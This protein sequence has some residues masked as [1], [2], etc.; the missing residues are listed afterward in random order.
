MTELVLTRVRNTLAAPFG[1]AKPHKAPLH[2][3]PDMCHDHAPASSTYGI[4]L[5]NPSEGVAVMWPRKEP[6]VGDCGYLTPS[7][8]FLSLFNVFET[9][10]EFPS[11]PRP[12]EDDFTTTDVPSG[13]N[14]TM[15]WRAQRRIS[16]PLKTPK[17]TIFSDSVE[18]AALVTGDDFRRIYACS[19]ALQDKFQQYLA[20][21]YA[22][23]AERFDGHGIKGKSLIIVSQTTQ[24][25]RFFCVSQ[26]SFPS[27]EHDEDDPKIWEVMRK[28]GFVSNGGRTGRTIEELRME[29]EGPDHT[30]MFTPICVRT[31]SVCAARR[32]EPTTWELTTE[33]TGDLVK[34]AAYACVGKQYHPTYDLY[35]L[36]DRHHPPNA[37]EELLDIALAENRKV[38]IAVGSWS[39]VQSLHEQCGSFPDLMNVRLKVDVERQ[40]KMIIGHVRSAS[41]VAAETTQEKK[42]G[43][44][45]KMDIDSAGFDNFVTSYIN[46]LQVKRQPTTDSSLIEIAD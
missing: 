32:P 10:H 6:R 3:R 38:D 42:E 12:T 19:R 21:N 28:T 26:K 13:P 25:V 24:L 35:D 36:D 27:V 4:V 22:A 20:D 44:N 1:G 14:H 18:D 29:P 7:T 41:V 5:Q 2:R 15:T 16:V 11:I 9:T 43:S 30:V 46:Q 17:G 33:V 8:G 45:T 37:L 39:L 34:M 31:R 40:E 23:I